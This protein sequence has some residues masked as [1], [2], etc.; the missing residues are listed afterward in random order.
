[1]DSLHYL[2]MKA[3]AQLNK[4]ILKNAAAIDLSPGQPKILEDLL[5]HGENNQKAVAEHCE[6]EQA[7]AG[8]ILLRM[9]K[10][11][12]IKRFNKEGNRRSLYVT[13]T[14]KGRQRALQMEQIFN[15]CEQEAVSGMSDA[16]IQQL[17]QLLEKFCASIAKKGC[18]TNEK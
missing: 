13:L 17:K 6:I 16:E 8:T 5:C 18:G 2:L 15:R 9:E 4:K 14:S 1:M 12:L 11:G 3:Y 7:T 10:E